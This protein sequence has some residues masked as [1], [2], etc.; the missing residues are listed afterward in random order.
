MCSIAIRCGCSKY[1]MRDNRASPVYRTHVL[2]HP[3]VQIFPKFV[4][5]ED[6]SGAKVWTVHSLDA[7]PSH[8]LRRR[9]TLQQLAEN[10]VNTCGLTLEE[11]GH[12]SARASS[13]ARDTGRHDGACRTARYH[14]GR[15]RCSR[16]YVLG[17]TIMLS[18]GSLQPRCLMTYLAA[19]NF[20]IGLH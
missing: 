12:T 10:L 17:P 3:G 19:T 14:V 7:W 16:R 20:L 6:G 9:E 2:N 15:A 1:T 13:R 5:L 18:L 11:K 8:Q 4:A